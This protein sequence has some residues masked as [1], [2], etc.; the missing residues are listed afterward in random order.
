M[1]EARGADP[2]ALILELTE[3]ERAPDPAVAR[4]LL[5]RLREAGVGVSMDDYGVGYSDF[6]RLQYYPFSD[7]KIDRGLVAR[8]PDDQ[9]ARDIVSM[10]ASLAV[11]EGVGLTG[12]GI[13]TQEQWDMLEAL[14]CNFAQGF[15]I[16]RPMPADR[17]TGWIAGVTNAGRYRAPKAG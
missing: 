14:G 13:E 2:R 11:R 10:L 16:A 17:V 3:T 4:D 9:E 8:L 12:E 15:L 6:G 5:A 7:L 1:L